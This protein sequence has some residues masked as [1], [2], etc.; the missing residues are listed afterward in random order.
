V[1][2][3]AGSAAVAAGAH[4]RA[5]DVIGQ[6]RSSVA[7]ELEAVFADLLPL[8]RTV[9]PGKLAATL[10][11]LA[12]ALEGRGARLGRN[13][14]LVDG[15][16]A[17]LNPRLP[18]VQADISGLADLA[19]TY[20]TA[21]PELV[22]A[23]RNLVTTNTTI[24]QKRDSLAGFLAGTAGFANTA[25]DFLDA[26]GQR[27]VQVGRVNRPTLQTFARYAPEYPCLASGLA[28]WI[29]TIDQAWRDDTFHI[30]IESSPQRPGYRPGEEP[31][32]G[33]DRGPRCYNLPHPTVP[34]P[35]LHFSDGTSAGGSSA[36]SALPQMF[37]GQPGLAIGDPDSGLAGTRQ[38]QQ[39]VT[40]L[41]D[42]GAS[43]PSAI[44]TLLAGPML[45]G[46]VVNQS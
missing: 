24:V 20:A 44:T 46:T 18:V 13:L 10:N 34:R 19:S 4:L 39:L 9:Q 28:N 1:S 23:A 36:G 22:V 40:A 35:G 41:L 42:P 15:Y 6:D 2:P 37:T 5:G 8:L 45:R 14:V 11:A 12:G 38:E 16:F 25:A 7:V 32:W 26:N 31:A 3:V 27:L 21:A 29:P 43:R 30:T 17:R 33:E